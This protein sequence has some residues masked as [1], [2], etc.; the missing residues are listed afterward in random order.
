MI[1]LIMNICPDCPRKN[2]KAKWTGCIKHFSAGCKVIE[3]ANFKNYFTDDGYEYGAIPSH[4]NEVV[5]QEF[6]ELVFKEMNFWM[7]EKL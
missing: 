4:L 5:N 6:A 7:G 3:T 2:T 1:Q